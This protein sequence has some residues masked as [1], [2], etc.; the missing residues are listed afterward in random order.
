[1]REVNVLLNA[2]CSPTK[3]SFEIASGG[4]ANGGTPGAA[5]GVEEDAGRGGAGGGASMAKKRRGRWV[6]VN[7]E[8]K[9]SMS[10][11]WVPAAVQSNPASWEVLVVV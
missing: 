7:S 5:G 8:G 10:V 3:G 4:D 9:E 2:C 6:A 11:S 1:L